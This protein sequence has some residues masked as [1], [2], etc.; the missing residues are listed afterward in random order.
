VKRHGPPAKPRAEVTAAF[1][2]PCHFTCRTCGRACRAGCSYS[3][4][5]DCCGVVVAHVMGPDLVP[6]LISDPIGA[7][8]LTGMSTTTARPS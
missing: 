5:F 6:R 3:H 7:G 2:R 8:Y 1:N 4:R